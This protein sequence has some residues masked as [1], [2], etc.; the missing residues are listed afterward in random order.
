MDVWTINMTDYKPYT[1]DNVCEGKMSY[2]IWIDLSHTV[3]LYRVESI[4]SMELLCVMFASDNST[5]GDYYL[6]R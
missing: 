5:F 6:N 2:T 4:P 1:W 3:D